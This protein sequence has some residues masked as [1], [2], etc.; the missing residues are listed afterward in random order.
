[1]FDTVR[2]YQELTLSFG[3]QLQVPLPLKDTV[4]HITAAASSFSDLPLCD[5]EVCGQVSNLICSQNAP[6]FQSSL[7]IHSCCHANFAS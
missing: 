6:I 1:M 4:V 5:F 7:Q 3:P 2:Q